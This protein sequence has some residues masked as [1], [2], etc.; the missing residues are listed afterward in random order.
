MANISQQL[1][2]WC[3]MLII[4]IAASESARVLIRLLYRILSVIARVIALDVENNG[5][6]SETD[7]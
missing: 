3:I 5:D 4:L 2:V 6:E 7:V 1:L